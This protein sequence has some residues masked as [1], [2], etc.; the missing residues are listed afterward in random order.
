[1]SLIVFMI[2]IILLTCSNLLLHGTLFLRI[3]CSIAVH[4]DSISRARDHK[5]KKNVS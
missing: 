2:L 5:F 3:R 4:D 1:M